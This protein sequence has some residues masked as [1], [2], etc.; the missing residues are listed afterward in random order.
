MFDCAQGAAAAV[1]AHESAE[2]GDL[3][4][5]G[6]KLAVGC[7]GNVESLDA[8]RGEGKQFAVLAD[9]VL[10][11]VAPQAQIGKSGVKTVDLAI[12][13]GVFLSERG[14]TVGGSLVP[15]CAGVIY[16][17]LR[18]DE[19]WGRYYTDAPAKLNRPGIQTKNP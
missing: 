8:L 9:A 1:V 2:I 12:I 5:V 7:F 10:I 6:E 14:K 19:L 3:V 13:I 4:A 11:E 15:R 17:Q 16:R 18:R